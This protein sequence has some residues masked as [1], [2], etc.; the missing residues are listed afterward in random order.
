MDALL[1]TLAG[2]AAARVRVSDPLGRP[3]DAVLRA[4]RRRRH[5]ASSRW[6]RRAG[7][8]WSPRT[9]ATPGRPPRAGTGELIVAAV[10]AGAERVIVT[11]G[12]LRDDRRR[13]GRARGARRRGCDRRDGRALRRAH[14]VR[15]GA[16]RVRAAEGRRRRDGAQAR[17]SGSTGCAATLRRDPR[18]EPMTGCAR[19][20]VRGALG[21]AR[22]APAPRRRP[23]CWTRSAST[24]ACARRRSWSRARA[25]STSRRCRARSSA[26]SRRAAAKAGS[27][28]TA[29][30]GRIELD[31][32]SPAH[33]RPRVADGGHDA[34]R[35]CGE[36]GA[37]D[38]GV[39]GAGGRRRACPARRSTTTR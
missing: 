31:P 11:V 15:A 13:R 21:R 3:V 4:D 9:S 25:A 26:R 38:R 14:A 17:R 30:V 19:R 5:G 6:R 34:G 37:L 29:V 36:P 35:A 23:T 20:P 8:A 10:E 2:R 1:S 27:P 18:G 32:F 22:G 16:A 39:M 12:R 24:S 33:P 28:A 7:W